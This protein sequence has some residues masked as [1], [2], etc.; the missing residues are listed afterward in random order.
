MGPFK[1]LAAAF[2]MSMCSEG[3]IAQIADEP[4]WAHSRFGEADRIGAANHLSANGVVAAAGLVK[5][6]KVYQLGVKTGPE[7]PAFGDSRSYTVERIPSGADITTHDG[8]ERPTAFDEKVTLSMGIGTQIDGLAHLG[9]DNRAYNGVPY[10]ELADSRELDTA[11]I[12]PF[13]T[14]GVLI[15]MT[16]H[17]GVDALAAGQAF[18]EAEIKAAAD[19][20]GVTIKTGDVVLFHTGWMGAHMESD[21]DTFRSQ[22][23]GIGYGGAVYL[24]E[25]GV[26]AIGA[27]TVAL[28][29]IPFE[30]MR[31]PFIV[32][33]TMLA[34]YGVYVLETID[35][36]ELAA[37]GLK[38]F[39]FVA[40]PPRFEG[41]V[42]IVVNPVAIG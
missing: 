33:Q 4:D 32:H 5:T 7:T 17:F 18:N 21:P 23:P 12:P 3:A 19:A 25:L 42:Q 6:G 22:Q 20:Q 13:V 39:M 2:V 16:K 15:D 36:R 38:E 41:T 26:V 31:K 8:S 1:R 29:A 30:D 28:E 34:K 14:R 10:T 35:T 24:S 11:G 37:D 9:I 40:A 27:D